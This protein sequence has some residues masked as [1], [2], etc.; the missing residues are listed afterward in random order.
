[1]PH[2]LSYILGLTVIGISGFVCIKEYGWGLG[3]LY[4]TI[5]LVVSVLVGVSLFRSGIRWLSLAPPKPAKAQAR[6]DEPSDPPLGELVQVVQPLH[7][8]G[9]VLWQGRRLPARSLRAERESAVG[10][11]VAVRGRDSIYLLVE[12]AESDAGDA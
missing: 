11:A 4:L 3:S 6:P 1:L 10:E 9:T 5:A 8:T 2:G 12:P 7:P